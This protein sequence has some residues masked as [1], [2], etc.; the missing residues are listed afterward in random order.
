MYTVSTVWE[1]IA[2]GTIIDRRVWPAHV[3]LASNFVVEAPGED[4]VLAVSTADVASAPL[5]VEF[6]G[7]DLFGPDRDIPVQLVVSEL[8][9][10]VH[11]RLA[12]ELE[13]V[14]GFCAEVESH[15]RDGYRPHVTVGPGVSTELAP[16]LRGVILSRLEGCYAIVAAAWVLP[17]PEL[18]FDDLS[19]D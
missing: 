13:H 14:R 4:V 9:V 16:A 18:P 1:P 3:T 8:A 5:V 19:T 7:V 11:G 17:S 12:E 15:W 6:G 2:A 10:R